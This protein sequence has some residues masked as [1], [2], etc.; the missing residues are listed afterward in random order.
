[1]SPA[2]GAAITPASPAASWKARVG[3]SRGTEGIGNGYKA[4][5]VLESRFEADTGGPSNRPP[6]SG[7]QLPDRLTAGLPPAVQAALN[8]AVGSQLG[9]NLPG[10]L[11]DRQAFVGMVTPFGAILAGRQ[12]TPAFEIS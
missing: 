8:S 7:T 12:Y 2:S 11:F 1:M 5:F 3:A 9:V 10:R 6:V 4:M